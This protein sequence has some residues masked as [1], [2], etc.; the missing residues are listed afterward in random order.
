MRVRVFVV[1]TMKRV[2]RD[3]AHGPLMALLRCGA[4]SERWEDGA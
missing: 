4:K 2:P 1:L 3:E